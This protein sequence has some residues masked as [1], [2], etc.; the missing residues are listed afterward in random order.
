MKDE[1]SEKTEGSE[2]SE[3]RASLPFTTGDGPY[4]VGRN[5]SLDE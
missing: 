5:G 3:G 1:E 4:F 2:R